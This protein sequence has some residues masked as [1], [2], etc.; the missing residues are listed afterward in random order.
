MICD[1]EYTASPAAQKSLLQRYSLDRESVRLVFIRVIRVQQL[2]GLPERLF[3]SRSAVAP[4]RLGTIQEHE[5]HELDEFHE[6][7]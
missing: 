3:S 2:S 5:W 1:R 6:G 4:I 7:D